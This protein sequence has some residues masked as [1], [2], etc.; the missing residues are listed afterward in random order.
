M[1]LSLTPSGRLADVDGTPYIEA[2]ITYSR[3]QAPP[4]GQTTGVIRR[5]EDH[6]F[7]TVYAHEDL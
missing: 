2:L 6:P 3:L 7:P 5:E 4:T 1:V